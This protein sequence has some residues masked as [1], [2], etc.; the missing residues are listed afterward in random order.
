M[1]VELGQ[2]RRSG[3]MIAEAHAALEESIGL[4]DRIGDEDRVLAAAVAFGAPALW[5]SREWGETDARLVALLERQL[6]RIAGTDPA[7]RVRILSTLAGELAFGE[8]VVRS[9]GYAQEALGIAR[10]L[11][12]PDELGIAISGYLLA[13]LGTDHLAERRAVIDEMLSSDRPAL[14]PTAQALLRARRLT[15]R[16]RSGE[17]ARFDA[18]FPPVW[19]LAADVLHSPELQ[20]QLR[21][22]QACRYYVAGDVD[23]GAEI[24][25]HTF[26]T[27]ADVT[28]P[29]RQRRVSSARAPSCSSP[30]RWPIRPNSWR[31][32][33]PGRTI[34]PCPTWPLPPPRWVSPSAA[35]CGSARDRVRLVR[36]AAAVVDL[37]PGGR[38]LGPGRHRARRAGPRVAARAAGAARR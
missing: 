17:L 22:A 16:I 30:A 6:A 23:R 7:R 8:M 32:A 26:R 27:M 18:E 31:R 4:A 37:D 25:G 5:G 28:G 15:E 34:H 10:Q 36:A 13:G 35:T 38:L 20:A 14:T 19:A 21:F 2:A 24:A 11:G 33:S 3:S 12:Q 9:W 1:L 29:W